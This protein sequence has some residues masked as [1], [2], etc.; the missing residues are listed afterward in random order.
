MPGLTQ[1]RCSLSIRRR[2][3]SAAP[4]R[5]H[6]RA[7]SASPVAGLL[8]IMGLC[9]SGGGCAALCHTNSVAIIEHHVRATNDGLFVSQFKAA[10]L[11]PARDMLTADPL[12][13]LLF[14]DPAW[15]V[16]DGGVANGRVADSSFYTERALS[17]LSPERVGQGPGPESAPVQPFRIDRVKSTGATAGF[18]GTDAQGRKFLVKLDHPH[19]PELG[20][21]ASIIAARI[22]HALGYNVPATF[23]VTVDGTGDERFDG[24]RAVASPLIPDVLG[25]FQYDWFRYR[26]EVRGLRLV[27]AW[28]NDTDRTAS[29]TLVTVRDGA[30]RYYLIDFN[31]ALGAWQGRPKE[32]RRGWRYEVGSPRL[33]LE[34]LTLGLLRPGFDPDQPVFSRAVGRFD[35]AFDHMTWVPQIANTAFDHMTDDDRRWIIERIARLQRP[36]L[37]A[38]VAAAG[39][40]DPRNRAYLVDT[41]LARQARVLALA[42]VSGRRFDDRERATD[43]EPPK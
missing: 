7:V 25:H 37:E 40:S 1:H 16:I 36:Q 30:A 23:L 39:L 2:S 3:R 10:V 13:R 15:N 27:A 41:L 43:P 20:S 14:G 6:P 38:I 42:E 33:L 28:L 24:R 8:I 11:Y 22:Y 9:W 21:S 32:P 35:A 29:N 5:S 34:I 19:F 12:W 31:S 4:A 18:F 17:D 26:R